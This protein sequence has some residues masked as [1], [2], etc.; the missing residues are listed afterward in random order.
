MTSSEV[1]ETTKQS[2]DHVNDVIDRPGKRRRVNDDIDQAPIEFASKFL[3]V[4]FHFKMLKSLYDEKSNSNEKIRG[5][6]GTDNIDEVDEAVWN[7][8]RDFLADR[9]RISESKKE[10]VLW[11]N[12]RRE[13]M[14][15]SES[16]TKTRSPTKQTPG[17][18]GLAPL[19]FHSKYTSGSPISPPKQSQ[20]TENSFFIIA[21]FL[22]KEALTFK[23]AY[24]HQK[25]ALKPLL[26]SA[27]QHIRSLGQ[28]VAVLKQTIANNEQKKL[29]LLLNGGSF[30]NKTTK[31]ESSNGSN[32]SR[33]AELQTKMRLWQLLEADLRSI[34]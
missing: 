14:E 18:T 33:L 7:N 27:E 10:A 26:A 9:P 24:S 30:L 22:G 23:D 3:F 1:L 20:Q 13:A 31:L 16:S 19:T 8:I 11:D 5:K 28:D 25:L 29:H 32:E 21:Q 2:R 34:L 12:I 6:K 4:G 17:R 15:L